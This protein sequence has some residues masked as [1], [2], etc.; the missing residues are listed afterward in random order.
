VSLVA[1]VNFFDVLAVIGAV[2]G[3]LAAVAEVVS[4]LRDRPKLIVNFGTTTSESAPPSCWLTVLNDG[5]QPITLRYAGFYG[6]EI[7]IRI[8]SREHGTLYPVKPAT[9]Q[10][11]M[12][13]EPVLLDSG[14]MHKA[15][16]LIP[17]SFD[18]GYH[19][20]F[21]L[22]AFADDA[23]GRRIWGEAAPIVRMVV[24][25]GPCPDGFPRHLWEP[26]SKPL[27]PAQV[28]PKWKLWKARELRRG[29]RG[30]P[31]ADQLEELTGAEAEA[32]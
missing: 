17:D 18:H 23:R 2:T 32:S 22:R 6:S 11:P 16:A 28:E 1:D 15:T 20:D 13:R 12:I 3:S 21:P 27:E 19:V 5:R 25:G 10:F 29:D 26:T 8:E 24:G 31:S 9:Y 7:P 30:R 4:V 14:Q